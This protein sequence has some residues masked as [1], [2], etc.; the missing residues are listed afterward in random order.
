MRE[1]CAGMRMVEIPEIS[2]AALR[3]LKEFIAPLCCA[4]DVEKIRAEENRK[5]ARP[6]ESQQADTVGSGL[7]RGGLLDGSASSDPDKGEGQA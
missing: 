6:Y 2:V 7:D 3:D 1:R 4:T 5:E